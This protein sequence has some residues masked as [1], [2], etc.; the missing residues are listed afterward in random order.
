MARR[1]WPFLLL[2]AALAGC[3]PAAA[4]GPDVVGSASPA[5]S[6]PVAAASFEAPRVT[7]AEAY[8]RMQKGEEF[9]FVDVRSASAY[10]T[11]HIE[12]AISHPWQNNA[13]FGMLP[14]EKLLLL[15]CT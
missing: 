4:P 8:A 11:G 14:K 2:A 1:L 10:A 7:P 13:S 12:G 3:A 5:P 15:Y 9:V 6:A